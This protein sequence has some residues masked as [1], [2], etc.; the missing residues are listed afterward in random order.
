VFADFVFGTSCHIGDGIGYIQFIRIKAFEGEKEE[1]KETSMRKC[2][3]NEVK[4]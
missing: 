1:E 2:V 4:L 3:A